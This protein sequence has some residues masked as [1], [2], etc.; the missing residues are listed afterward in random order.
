MA[1]PS[2]SAFT[3]CDNP[4]G[5]KDSICRT[6]LATVATATWEADLEPAEHNHECDPIRMKQIRN[7]LGNPKAIERRRG[8]PQ[9]QSTRRPM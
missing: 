3:H 6:C 4:D 9:H 8:S 5:T 2:T 7:F 1:Q